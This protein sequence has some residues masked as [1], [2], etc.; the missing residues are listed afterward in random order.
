[1]FTKISKAVDKANAE[2]ACQILQQQNEEALNETNEIT[3]KHI[4]GSLLF[5]VE[6]FLNSELLEPVPH[7]VV[8]TVPTGLDKNQ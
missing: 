7:K 4:Q 5:W 6:F 1:M 3:S 8:N 2:L